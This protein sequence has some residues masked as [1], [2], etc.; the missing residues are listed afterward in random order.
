MEALGSTNVLPNEV[1]LKGTFRAMDEGWRHEA[2]K[3]LAALIQS[4]CQA[5]GCE[6]D[7]DIRLGYPAVNNHVGMAAAFK[8]VACEYLEAAHVHDLDI[9]MTGE[10]FSYFA[11]EIPGCFYRLGTAYRSPETTWARTDCTRQGST[12]TKKR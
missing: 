2:H 1:R 3:A 7:L 10:D 12:W 6:A 8:A 4:T 9:R 5:H 11:N